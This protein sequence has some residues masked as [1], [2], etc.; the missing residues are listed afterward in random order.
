MN[1]IAALLLIVASAPSDIEVDDGFPSIIFWGSLPDELRFS[2]VLY[3]DLRE[4]ACAKTLLGGEPSG[5][6]VAARELWRRHSR[7]HAVDVLRFLAGPP[8]GGNDYRALQREID[9]ALHS[10][11]VLRELREGDYRWGAWLAFLRPHESY[12]PILLSAVEQ[13][14]QVLPETTLALGNS[15]DV[16][17]IEPLLRMLK[18][19][20]GRTAGDAALALGFFGRQ[21]FEPHLIEALTDDSPWVKMRVCQALAMVGTV[22]SLP[23]LR[24]LV[25][26]DTDTS[27]IDINGAAQTAIDSIERR[28]IH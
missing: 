15:G 18:N 10:E 26:D 21:E 23:A 12:V 24:I 16:R 22:Q 19:R 7:K 1:M 8:P 13:Q 14:P 2:C 6:V 4:D 11:A 3:T 5:R 20:E 17:A 9:S 25:R 28:T 27:A